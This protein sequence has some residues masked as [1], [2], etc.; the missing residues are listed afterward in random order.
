MMSPAGTEPYNPETWDP[1]K[2]RDHND[3][4]NECMEKSKVDKILKALDDKCHPLSE[5]HKYPGFITK[6]PTKQWTDSCFREDLYSE[7]IR[8]AAFE[9]FWHAISKPSIVDAMVL[10]PFKYDSYC[11]H[12]LQSKDRLGNPAV[13]FPIAIGFGD[14]DYLGTEGADELVR[15]NKHFKTGRS[16]LF[17]IKDCGHPVPL[18]APQE[19]VEL[20]I[21]F[22]EG[23][24]TGRFDLKPRG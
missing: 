24:I 10:L 15:N 18:D 3:L 1:Y 12:P 11:I 19:T 2:L 20:M 5:L 17:T 7:T 13:D 8:S 21:G 23:H 9:Y 22:F 4:R 16:Q 14:R 6:I